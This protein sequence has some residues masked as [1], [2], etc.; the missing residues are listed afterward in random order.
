MTDNQTVVCTALCGTASW[1]KETMF[2]FS[3]MSSRRYCL[4][5]SLT[6]TKYRLEVQW[7]S[8]LPVFI[9]S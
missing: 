9:I 8:Y 4:L 2:L 7:M 5:S 1:T 3:G 6:I